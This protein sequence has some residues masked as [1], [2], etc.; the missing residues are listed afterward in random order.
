MPHNVITM[1]LHYGVHSNFTW[2]N[3]NY[4]KNIVDNQMEI[5]LD[6]NT[7]SRYKIVTIPSVL[8]LQDNIL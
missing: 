8:I 4:K 1:M 3:K 2:I 5:I 7:I 6:P